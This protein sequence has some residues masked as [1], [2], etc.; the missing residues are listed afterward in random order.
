MH[1]E[2]LTPLKVNIH[3]AE[4][5]SKLEDTSQLKEMAQIISVSS[6]LVLFHANDLLDHRIFESGKFVPAYQFASV[7]NALV[8]IV[9]MMRWTVQNTSLDIQFTSDQN[10]MGM[11]YFDKRRLQQVLL[12]LLSNAVKFQAAGRILV[13]LSI[14]NDEGNGNRVTIMVS[15]TD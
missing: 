8:E 7:S 15:V 3:I 6:K 2:I 13:K 5:L 12:N 10:D 11:H 4:K 1:H 14:K 9:E